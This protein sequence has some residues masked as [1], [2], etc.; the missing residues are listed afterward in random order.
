MVKEQKKREK[1]RGENA[2]PSLVFLLAINNNNNSNSIVA[3][4]YLCS[5]AR[6]LSFVHSSSSK[7]R[8]FVQ[9]S[10]STQASVSSLSMSY[11]CF[12]FFFCTVFVRNWSHSSLVF[13]CCAHNTR[14]F[15][16]VALDFFPSIHSVTSSETMLC[17]AV[18]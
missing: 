11:Q 16:S 1:E 15:F 18:R 17:P 9:C 10:S 6:A 14:F 7:C 12:P 8:A 3:F 2:S 4:L 5:K 13:Y